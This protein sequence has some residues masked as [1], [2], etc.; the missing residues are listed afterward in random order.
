MATSTRVSTNILTATSSFWGFAMLQDLWKARKCYS[1][2]IVPSPLHLGKFFLEAPGKSWFIARFRGPIVFPQ[3]IAIFSNHVFCVAAWIDIERGSV[4][5]CNNK[6]LQ[7]VEIEA[8]PIGGEE[9]L[10]L[11]LKG[12]V[13]G[14]WRSKGFLASTSL[15]FSLPILRISSR[16]GKLSFLSSW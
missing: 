9:N 10:L 8:L 5:P 15:V 11:V 14:N 16:I 7:L 1:T 12:T 2:K 3:G 13:A 6:E 4:T